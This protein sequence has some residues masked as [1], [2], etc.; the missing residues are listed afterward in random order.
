[1][2]LLFLIKQVINV[3]QE[4]SRTIYTSLWN[5]MFDIKYIVLLS[6]TA[7]EIR[8]HKSK[9]LLVILMLMFFNYVYV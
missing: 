1:M 3:G 5:A 6:A 4:E 2:M 8:L 9:Y 7:L